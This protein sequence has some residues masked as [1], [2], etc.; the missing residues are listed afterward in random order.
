[1]SWFDSEKELNSESNFYKLEDGSN[2][3][4]IVS[5]PIVRKNHWKFN[6]PYKCEGDECVLCED[7][8]EKVSYIMKRF[9]FRIIDRKT[10][11][12]AVAEFAPSVAKKIR[13][14][15]T[16][17]DGEYSYPKDEAIA[18]YDITVKKSG[19]G[20]G[21]EYDV[22]PARKNVELTPEEKKL[23]E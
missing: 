6:K 1:M 5:E 9:A 23:I 21:T 22:I 13:E 12:L 15:Q 3:L 19:T 16:E 8:D 17:K 2:K 14:F 7:K 20:L 11:T 4:R 18:P 10:N